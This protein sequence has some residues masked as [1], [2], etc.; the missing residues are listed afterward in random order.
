MELAAELGMIFMVHVSDPDTWFATK[1]RDPS[2]YGT[3]QSQYEPLEPLLERFPRPWIAAHMAG[4]PEDL[5]FL[6]KLRFHDDSLD[7]M[8]FARYKSLRGA[9]QI[10]DGKRDWKII[11]A[12]E[13]YDAYPPYPQI[14]IE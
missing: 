4:S 7:G 10:T 2:L 14:K 1:Y 12:R 13:K 3:K 6:A 5:G 8:L 11:N 9:A